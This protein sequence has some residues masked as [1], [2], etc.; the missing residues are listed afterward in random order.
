MGKYVDY[1]CKCNNQNLIKVVNRIIEKHFGWLPQKDYD[2]MYS[3]AGK[4]VW[5]CEK[6]FD[7]HKRIKFSTYLTSCLIKKF[8]SYITYLN[9]SKRKCKDINGNPLCDVSINS[10]ID[11]TNGT[12]MNDVLVGS[13]D[14]FEDLTL[15][16]ENFGI[17]VQQYFNLLTKQQQDIA[18]LISQGY[19]PQEIMGRLNISKDRYNSQWGKMTSIRKTGCLY[20][21]RK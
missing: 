18:M 7:S 11:E 5:D 12:E 8:K 6:K 13:M 10:I 20:K 16:E 15:Y 21:E 3:I 1:Y 14:I 2:D 9:R 19:K 17:N 4:V